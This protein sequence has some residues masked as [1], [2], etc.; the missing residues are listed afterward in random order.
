MSIYEN[1]KNACSE[2]GITVTGLEKKLGFSR[3]SICKWD[4]HNPNVLKMSAVS[5]ELG[6]P[7]DYF[8]K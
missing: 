5:K 2:K 7:I 6:K 4:T 1:V 3:G 8:L